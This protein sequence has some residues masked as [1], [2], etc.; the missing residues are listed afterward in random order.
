MPGNPDLGIDLQD[1][2]ILVD[3]VGFPDNAPIAFSVHAFFTPGTVC[4]EYFLFRIGKQDKG[5]AVFFGKTPVRFRAVGAYTD[6]GNSVSGI[7]PVIIPETAGFFCT[8][9]S[10]IFGIKIQYQRFAPE[11]PQGISVPLRILKIE[12]WSGI[13]DP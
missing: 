2:A 10:V 8:A 5:Q 13:I 12:I 6:N 1:S 11:L 4:P 7:F 3:K 9:G